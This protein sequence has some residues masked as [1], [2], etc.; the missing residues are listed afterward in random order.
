MVKTQFPSHFF[1]CNDWCYRNDTTHL[2]FFTLKNTVLYFFYFF[3]LHFNYITVTFLH[4]NSPVL[5]LLLFF[6]KLHNFFIDLHFNETTVLQF[7]LK[8]NWL[9]TYEIL[10]SWGHCMFCVLAEV[11]LRGITIALELMDWS[12]PTHPLASHR[13]A[14]RWGLSVVR[15]SCCYGAWLYLLYSQLPR[16][17]KSKC[18]VKTQNGLPAPYWAVLLALTKILIELC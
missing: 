16:L 10:A 13:E 4:L 5:P 17:S 7:V 8:P 3:V 6:N 12:P 11:H 2:L 9:Y 18:C 15:T 14:D 1:N